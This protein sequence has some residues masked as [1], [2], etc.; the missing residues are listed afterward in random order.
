MKKYLPIVLQDIIDEIALDDS[1]IKT[2][3]FGI[4]F[5][6]MSLLY[7]PLAILFLPFYLFGRALKKLA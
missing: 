1:Y 6:L 5:I 4:S 3:F 2:A 7:V